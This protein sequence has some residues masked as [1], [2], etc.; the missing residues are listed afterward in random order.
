[1]TTDRR[2][3]RRSPATA[4]PKPTQGLSGATRLGRRV[5]GR[6]GTP[7]IRG[8]LPTDLEEGDQAK[9]APA[10]LLPATAPGPII[11]CAL[12]TGRRPSSLREQSP[13]RRRRAWFALLP[14]LNRAHDHRERA[15]PAEHQLGGHRRAADV[16]G[17]PRDGS[18][19]WSIGGQAVTRASEPRRFSSCSTT[20]DR[21]SE[22]LLDDR[23]GVRAAS[24]ARTSDPRQERSFDSNRRVRQQVLR[25]DV[26]GDNPPFAAIGLPLS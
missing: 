3:G 23:N 8:H 26:V 13:I 16:T 14:G 7:R 2:G 1:L 12:R 17:C 22:M 18:T 10:I 20:A 11:G 24:S 5:A 6:G 15:H 25:A 21:P 4:D 9:G 19:S